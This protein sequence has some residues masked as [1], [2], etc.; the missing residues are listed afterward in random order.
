M[1]LYS[2]YRSTAAYR[3][4]IALQYK[5][6]DYEYIPVSLIENKQLEKDYR[7]HNPQGRVPTLEDGDLTLGQSMAILEYLEE[8]YPH[9]AL[10]PQDINARAWIRYFSQIIACD[11]HPLNNLGAVNFLRDRLGQRQEQITAWYHHW[12]R[13]GFDTLEILLKNNSQ[14]G[15]YCWG[16]S[17][18]F[19]DLCLVPQVY[20]AY[21]FEFSLDNY[22]LIKQIN[23]H[24]L[25]QPFF[26]L[27]T[28]EQQPDYVNRPQTATP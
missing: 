6:L 1:K 28:P 22:P 11:I 14:R 26:A 3:V 21:R 4:R 20:N 16:N 7:A 9:P 5:Q 13:Q 27:A 23:D 19:A 24:C 17:P 18:T 12:L 2:Y 25:S 15:L 8:K 10:L